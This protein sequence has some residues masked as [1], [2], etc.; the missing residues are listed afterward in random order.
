MLQLVDLEEDLGDCIALEHCHGDRRSSA[1]WA[2]TT[3]LIIQL[4]SLALPCT[5][6][7]LLLRLQTVYN[8]RHL[9]QSSML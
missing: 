6:C 9:F 3:Q 7:L 8:F 1:S 5:P 2:H 4:Y